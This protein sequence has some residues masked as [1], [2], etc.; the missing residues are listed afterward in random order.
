VSLSAAK[1]ADDE[2]KRTEE[3]QLLE[4]MA[5]F[6][7]KE[8]Y[9]LRSLF[10]FFDL[11]GNGTI[12]KSELKAGLNAMGT[13]FKRPISSEEVNKLFVLLDTN[14]DGEIDY[15]EL[16]GAVNVPFAGETS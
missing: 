14:G 16:V 3:E 15:E 11:D 10:R 5:Q 12:S 2:R 1:L 4:E 6:L 7:F 9:Q 8:R 13:V